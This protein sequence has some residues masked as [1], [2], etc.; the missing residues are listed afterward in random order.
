MK[1]Y[2]ILLTLVLLST[3]LIINSCKK[4]DPGIADILIV[5]DR[6]TGEIFQVNL[7]TGEL[8]EVTQVMYNGTG[9]SEIRGMVYNPSNKTI[10][11]SST[12]NTIDGLTDDGMGR[13]YSINPETQVATR[14][15]SNPN[16]HWYGLPDIKITSDNKLLASVW[17][18]IAGPLANSA[19]GLIKFNL[20]GSVNNQYIFLFDD[21]TEADICCGMG[22]VEGASATELIVGSYE[23]EIYTSNLTGEVS[24]K[25]TLTLQGFDAASA[26]DNYYIK[27]MVKHSNTIYAVVYSDYDGITYLATVDLT[28][29][30]LIKVG[31]MGDETVQYHGLSVIPGNLF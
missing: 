21:A 25:G 20:D 4:D 28:N 19:P 10:Y 24:L 26:T 29:N 14:I 16:D 2:R 13:L 5:A 23:L 22:I 3:S 8:T 6:K 1:V 27:N 15:N 12:D 31:A 7:S 9:L 11:V 17:H 18:K 30:K